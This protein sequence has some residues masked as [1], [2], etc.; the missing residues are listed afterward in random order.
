MPVTVHV[1][2]ASKY[3]LP[4]FS[5]TAREG[6]Q[7][8]C[9]FFRNRE[10]NQ[11]LA[12]YSAALPSSD[13]RERSLDAAWL[14]QIAR[15]VERDAQKRGSR[16]HVAINLKPRGALVQLCGIRAAARRWSPNC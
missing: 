3:Q 15:F 5:V 7:A 9:G 16:R 10:V 11:S 12:K 2:L 4:D 6:L 13:W 1:Y 14:R 8:L